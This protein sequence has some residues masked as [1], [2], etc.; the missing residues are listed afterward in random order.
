M[1]EILQMPE[2]QPIVNWITDTIL[3]VFGYL[4]FWY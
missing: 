1:L 3:W 2:L 4:P